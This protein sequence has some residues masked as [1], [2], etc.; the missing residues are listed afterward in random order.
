M[1][2]MAIERAYDSGQRPEPL[3][4]QD[5]DDA[6]EWLRQREAARLIRSALEG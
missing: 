1:A 3:A 5:R 4:S 6:P 2:L